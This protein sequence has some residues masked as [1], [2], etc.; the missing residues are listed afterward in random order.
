MA[1]LGDETLGDENSLQG[2]TQAHKHSAPSSDGGFLETT[3]TGITNLSNGSIVYGNASEEVTELSSGNLNDVLT[4]G[5]TLPQWSPAGGATW[6]V[7]S[8]VTLNSNTTLSSG[9]F[10]AQDRFI[11]VLFYGASV[12]STTLGITCNASAGA[13]EYAYSSFRNYTTTTGGDVEKSMG[14]LTGVATDNACFLEMTGY[15]GG[16]TDDKLFNITTCANI[17]TGNTRPISYQSAS[18]Y[19]GG[20]YIT[21]FELTSANTGIMV[22]FQAGSRLL[23]LATG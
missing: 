2:R 13:D 16:E 19:Y 9:T 18:K 4:M 12:S 23:V 7:L 22:N 6:E 8:D 14:Y 11:K 15:N 3:I 10:S 21:S 1:T 17:T 20:D 5:A